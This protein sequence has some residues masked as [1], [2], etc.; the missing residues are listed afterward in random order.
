MDTEFEI[1]TISARELISDRWL[2]SLEVEVITKGGTIGRG[3]SPVG[4][5]PLEHEAVYLRDNNER[6][7]GYGVQEAVKNVNKIIAPKLKGIEIFEQRLIDTLMI[8]MDG[9]QDKSKL[10]ANSILS[11]SLAVADAASKCLNI[12]PYKYLGGTTANTLPVPWIH[13]IEMPGKGEFG[14]SRNLP[15][16]EHHIVPVGAK[17]FS[18]AFRKC[19]E[20]HY[21]SE[22]IINNRYGKPKIINNKL[23]YPV[24]IDEYEALDLII[25]SIEEIGYMD[26]FVLALDCAASHIFDREK[27]T[28]LLNNNE[29]SR[30][31]L[32]DFYKDLTT[33][34]PIF[35]LEDPLY[36]DDFE[37]HVILTKELGIQIVG[38]DLFVTNINRIQ[39]GIEMGAA[40][41]V[42]LKPN[43]I[44]TLTEAI[45]AARF[46]Q[47]K[48]Y[49]IVV[50]GRQGID[51]HDLIPDIAVALNTGQVKIGP[52]PS[53]RIKYNR[54]L[55]IE[56]ELGKTASYPG[57]SIL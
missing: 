19:I 53:R 29:V 57:R 27:E 50:S 31:N 5:R 47:T 32:I 17:N 23:Y 44:G 26:D 37:G 30:G 22:K 39:K 40:N 14:F 8:E 4:T 41:A 42:L 18:E 38:D 9:T 20:V 10:G 49:K 13:S 25:E 21:E 48:G 34:Y 15:F 54:L 35:A 2:P 45:D 56:E 24:I 1:K 43:Q 28:Y 52:L 51:E 46:A 3:A 6:Y 55:R 11:T 7:N 36:Q 33:K 16:Q 12:S